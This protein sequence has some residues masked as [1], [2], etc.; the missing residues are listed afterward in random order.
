MPYLSTEIPMGKK[1][2]RR[3]FIHD[4]PPTLIRPI[5]GDQCC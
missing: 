2:G 3:T 5:N 4:D 1:R